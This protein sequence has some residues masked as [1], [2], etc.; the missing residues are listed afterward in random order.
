MRTS[1]GGLEEIISPESFKYGE[2]LFFLY[3]RGNNITP[4][5]PKDADSWESDFL[6]LR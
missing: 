1:A 5:Y 4:T 3:M 2:I 6:A